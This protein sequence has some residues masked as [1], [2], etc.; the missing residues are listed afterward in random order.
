VADRL[1]ELA[2]SLALAAA[3]FVALVKAQFG[4]MPRSKDFAI[5]A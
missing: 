1:V 5:S 2:L 3:R 4:R